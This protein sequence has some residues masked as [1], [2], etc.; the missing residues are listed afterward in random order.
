M[1]TDYIVHRAG[2]RDDPTQRCAL[3]GEVLDEEGRSLFSEGQWIMERRD[4]LVDPPTVVERV[5]VEV[6][7]QPV[8][9]PLCTGAGDYVPGAGVRAVG[10]GDDILEMFDAEGPSRPYQV[11]SAFI[12]LAGGWLAELG[13]DF[14]SLTLSDL[15]TDESLSGW[16][17]H[18]VASDLTGYGISTRT[19]YLSPSWAKI[20][21]MPATEPLIIDKPSIVENVLAIY[22]RYEP[23][24]EDWRVHIFGPPDIDVRD[25]P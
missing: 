24:L 3:C 20:L 9:I 15:V 21:L 18:E 6:L 16:D 5:P 17:L 4:L 8:G 22:V 19:R 10:D 11:A 1:T 12:A 25:L 14:K 2:S 7:D 23:H 13:T